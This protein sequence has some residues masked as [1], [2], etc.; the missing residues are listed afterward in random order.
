MLMPIAI[1]VCSTL[2]GTSDDETR[3]AQVAELRE[4]KKR[5]V[6]DLTFSDFV[7]TS[8]AYR[9]GIARLDDRVEELLAARPGY[10][11]QYDSASHPSISHHARA[12]TEPLIL[13]IAYAKPNGKYHQDHRVLEAAEGGLRHFRRFIYPGCP[14]KGNWWAWQIGMP[15]RIIPTLTLLEG[16][17]DPEL[18]KHYLESVTYLL[19]CEKDASL[20]GPY[21]PAPRHP[22]GKTDTNSLWRHRLRLELA[23]LIENPAMAGKWAE[24]SFGEMAPAGQGH[25]QADYSFKFHGPIPMW[26]YG[27]TFLI[28]YARLL[29]CFGGTTFGAS[30]EELDRF[31][32]MAEHFANGFLYRSRICPAIIGREISRGDAPFISTA[33][34]M[35]TAAVGRSSHPRAREFARLARRECRSAEAEPTLATWVPAA[36]RGLPEVEPA[37]PVRDLFAYPDGDFLQVTRR[38]WAVGIK[39]HSK[40]NR[41]YES[42]NDENLQGWFLSHGS[43]FHFMTGNEWN[44]CWPTLDWTRLPGTTVAVEVRK[45]NE[46]GF[47]GALRASPEVGMAAMELRRDGFL[48]RKSWLVSGDHIICVGSDIAGPGRVET[49]VLNQPVSE[50]ATML[51]DGEPAPAG[52]FDKTVSPRWLWLGNTGYVLLG[53]QRLRVVRQARTSDWSSIRGDRL[54]GR[55]EPVT[56]HYLTAVIE[57]GQDSRSYAYAFVPNVTAERMP[58]V[59]RQLP[60]QCAVAR[61]GAHHVK[62][63][64]GGVESI[65][66]WGA[67]G[68]G[69]VEADRGCVLLRLGAKWWAVDPTQAEASI[70]IELDGKRH[71][72]SSRGGRPVPLR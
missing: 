56:R 68:L 64:D 40:R 63:A 48:A 2:V 10:W 6:A 50:D 11:A 65:V 25:L 71:V 31:A 43:M 14:Q 58:Q 33:G 16:R 1:L 21:R 9:D 62:A 24:Q 32:K 38:D 26:G 52:A 39:M 13:A 46:S 7:K 61:D 51:I 15:M 59:A 36:K 35:A 30:Q 34:L 47:V 27:R 17:L 20:Q 44:G 54:Y 70:H 28:D 45:Q 19:K 18:F 57:H 55:T 72:V 67:G 8:R 49:T 69:R 23:V 4:I 53:R 12:T 42:I 5:I 22:V 41:G 66:L 60:R 37:P 3:S 29:D